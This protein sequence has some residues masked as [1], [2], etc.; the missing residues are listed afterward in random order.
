MGKQKVPNVVLRNDTTNADTSQRFSVL[1]FNPR[2]N[3]MG[4]L[5]TYT[6]QQVQEWVSSSIG[7][8]VASV[9]VDISGS[10]LVHMKLEDLQALGLSSLQSKRILRQVEKDFGDFQRQVETMLN[11]LV[12][13]DN[14]TRT[15]EKGDWKMLERTVLGIIEEIDQEK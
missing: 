15:I 1:L 8:N 12:V 5:E 7:S 9:L 2:S 10:D 13:D 3:T 6:P 14:L 4:G 11:R